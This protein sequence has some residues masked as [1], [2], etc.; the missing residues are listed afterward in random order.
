M[1][2]KTEI[3]ISKVKTCLGNIRRRGETNDATFTHQELMIVEIEREI[4]DVYHP[5]EWYWHRTLD[6]E[7]SDLFCE[8]VI[9]LK[10]NEDDK[11]IV[12]KN[13]TLMDFAIEF[14]RITCQK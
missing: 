12:P 9:L 8:R 5:K 1:T 14:V 6:D 7:V 3:S 4:S 13:K 11:H 2:P 10:I